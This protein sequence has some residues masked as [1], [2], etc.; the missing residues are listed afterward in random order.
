[1]H[2]DKKKLHAQ[3]RSTPFVVIWSPH[4]IEL[5]QKITPKINSKVVD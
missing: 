1:M 5:K 2:G 4:F 3:L